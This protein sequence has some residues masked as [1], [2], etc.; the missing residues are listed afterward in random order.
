MSG[1][2]I[3]LPLQRMSSLMSLEH[4]VIAIDGY[5]SCGK[6]TVAKSLA[7]VLGIR[8][9]DSGAMY[10]AVTWY[11]L[12][13]KIYFPLAG[14]HSDLDYRPTLDQIHIHFEVNA[15]TGESEM[16]LNGH[17]LKKEIRSMEVSDNV[18][19]VSAIKEV[20]KR[21]V[22]LQQ[23][24]NTGAGLVMDGRDIGTTVFPNADLKIFMTADPEIRAMRRYREMLSAGVE[25]SLDDVRN[26]INSRD[27]EDTHREE[28]PLRMAPDAV[29]LDNSHLNFDEQVEF[30]L[31]RIR[32]LRPA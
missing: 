26:N 32:N 25:V 2:A 15:A 17:N 6:S 14:E 22:S 27:Y 24:M 9:I 30:V 20:R 18:S 31:E 3:C 8:Y 21:M 23:Q 10:R 1:R 5:S 4:P 19:H 7:K 16:F 13:N 11:F 29:V 12:E 28:S